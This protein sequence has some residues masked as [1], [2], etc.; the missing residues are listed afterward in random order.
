MSSLLSFE[1]AKFG[2]LCVETADTRKKVPEVSFNEAREILEVTN[3]VP[4]ESLV[5]VKEAIKEIYTDNFLPRKEPLLKEIK[6]MFGIYGTWW[7]TKKL[8]LSRQERKKVEIMAKWHDQNKALSQKIASLEVPVVGVSQDMTML[9]LTGWT[10]IPHRAQSRDQNCSLERAIKLEQSEAYHGLE[11][12]DKKATRTG[13]EA[14]DKAK[15]AGVQE[16]EQEPK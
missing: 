12:V 11:T 16:K 9:I 14:E 8:K 7:Q 15:R 4:K 10:W 13:Q 5:E 6:F 1:R 2:A 3:T